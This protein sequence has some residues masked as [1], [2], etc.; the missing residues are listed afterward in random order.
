MNVKIF[1]QFKLTDNA[2]DFFNMLE[3]ASEEHPELHMDIHD[4]PDEEF[5]RLDYISSSV[6][7]NTN[8]IDS[9]WFAY[10]TDKRV[11]CGI[12]KYEMSTGKKRP[13]T[14]CI[15]DGFEFMHC[16]LC[17]TFNCTDNYTLF[18]SNHILAKG[19][20]QHQRITLTPDLFV[21]VMD[22]NDDTVSGFLFDINKRDSFYRIENKEDFD[23]KLKT[24]MLLHA[25]M[26]RLRMTSL[27]SFI[28]NVEY[29]DRYL[30]EFN[31]LKVLP[32]FGYYEA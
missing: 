2:E 16:N 12:L 19:F 29:V 13:I 15:Y 32:D 8:V 11:H 18:Q 24:L 7:G 30:F 5:G 1:E 4:I 31:K 3:S 17:L 28:L 23:N 14:D 27:G 25:H 9:H 21:I 26:G 6:S 22:N 20:L 10:S